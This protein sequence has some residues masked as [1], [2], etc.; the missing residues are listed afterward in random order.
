VTHGGCGALC[1]AFAR[2]CFG[3]F[4]PADTVNSTAL[5]VRLRSGLSPDAVTRLFHTFATD[6][7]GFREVHAPEGVDP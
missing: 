1:P 4:G 2:G 5:V 6:A 3:C 7:P